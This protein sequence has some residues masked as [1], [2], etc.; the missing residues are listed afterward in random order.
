MT[1]RCLLIISFLLPPRGGT[2]RGSVEFENQQLDPLSL[3]INTRI[4]MTFYY[5][6]RY[7]EAIEQLRKTLEFDPD[8]ILVHIFLYSAFSE[9]GMHREAIPHLVKGFFHIY[10]SEERARIETT[11][12]AAY[13][14]SGEKGLLEKLRDILKGAE[15]RDYN[16]PYSMADTYMRLGEKD[17]AFLWLQKAMDVRHPGVGALKVAPVIDGLRTDERYSELL[18]QMNL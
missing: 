15:K 13:D 14:A 9:K 4:G 10:S 12:T 8:F 2:H 7:E 17:Q 1:I 6:R 18:R 5:S 11:L 16:Y 3:I